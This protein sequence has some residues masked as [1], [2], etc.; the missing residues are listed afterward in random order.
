[1]ADFDEHL[2]IDGFNIAHAWPDIEP[3]FNQGVDAVIERLTIDLLEIHDSRHV[4]LTV[5]FD[6]KGEDVE[7]LHPTK[8]DTFSQVFSPSSLT[9]D[10]VIEQMVSRSARPQTIQVATRDQAII[11]AVEALGATGISPD[12]LS[13]MLEACRRESSRRARKTATD[14]DGAWGNRIPL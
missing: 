3:L 13:E 5:V 2:I 4:R 7:I 9:A 1:M 10:A 11:D 8:S 6:G 12:Q 14:S